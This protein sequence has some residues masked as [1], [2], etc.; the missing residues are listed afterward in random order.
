M[1]P[2][3]TAA[4]AR[5]SVDR[6]EVQDINKL[7]VAFECLEYRTFKSIQNKRVEQWHFDVTLFNLG[8]EDY[9]EEEEI[10]ITIIEHDTE[11]E[12]YVSDYNEHFETMIWVV[13]ED[14]RQ[15]RISKLM[16]LEQQE[17]PWAINHD[18]KV[19]EYSRYN[20]RETITNAI[21]GVLEELEF[22]FYTT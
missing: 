9:I 18:R 21:L 13:D 15:D 2:G 12:D 3:D 11:H 14:P 20:A 22:V 10:I 17:H 1:R 8:E 16:G 6:V 4:F 7:S 5:A 19:T